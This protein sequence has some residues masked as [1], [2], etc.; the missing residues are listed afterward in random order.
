[1]PSIIQTY[2]QKIR[3]TVTTP[4]PTYTGRGAGEIGG[5]KFRVRLDDEGTP[6][7]YRRR[8]RNRRLTVATGAV[9]AISA[10]TYGLFAFAASG[11]G[12]AAGVCNAA[13][14]R[15]I[16]FGG[17][18][19]G[20]HRG[21]HFDLNVFNSTKRNALAADTAAQLKLR[22]FTIDLVINDPLS[23]GLTIPAQVRGAKSELSELQEVAAQVPG[24]QIETDSRTDPSVDLTLGTG[25]TRLA[26]RAS[27]C[28][29]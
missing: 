16:S 11:S 8:R 26:P 9:L 19:P 22:G 20:R 6:S 3:G 23:S 15:Q 4:L 7:R 12:T 24:A 14:T 17:T 25:F 10:C 21:T 28:A 1:M 27:S 2:I 29:H 18:A 5:K 13:S